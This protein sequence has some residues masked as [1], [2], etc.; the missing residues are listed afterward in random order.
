MPIYTSKKYIITYIMPFFYNFEYELGNVS[1]ENDKFS[2][3][4]IFAKVMSLFEIF[5]VKI[6][7]KFLN[8]KHYK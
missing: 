1:L 3:V 2:G 4:K 7:F 5:H 6:K 8:I